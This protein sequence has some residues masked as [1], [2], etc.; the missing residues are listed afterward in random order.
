MIWNRVKISSFL[1]ERPDRIKPDQANETGLKRLKK[2][3]FSGKIHLDGNK[4]TRTGMILVKKGDLVISGINAEKGAVAVYMGEENVLATIHYSSYDLDKDKIDVEY[5]KWFLKSDTFRSAINSQTKGGI[6]TELKPKKFL[7]L[8]I[9]LPDLD[10]QI[11]IRN[12]LNAVNNEIN[13]TID[14]QYENDKLLSK[15]RQ[16][17][18]SEAI[19]GKLIPQDPNDESASALLKKIK[20]EKEKLVEKKN[21]RKE[22]FPIITAE[23]EPYQPPEGWIWVRLGEISDNIHY[24]FNASAKLDKDI[25]LLRITDIQ[26]NRVN[27]ET[28]PGCEI[29]DKEYLNYSLRD[30]DIL[31]ARTGGTIG[32]SFIVKDVHQKAVFASYLIRVIPNIHMD[33]DYMKKFIESPLYWKQLYKASM[34]TGQPNVNGTSLKSLKFPLP[35]LNEQKRI[36]EKT[37]QLM[38]FCDQL[39]SQ[40]KS[41][42]KNSEALM[43]SVVAEAFEVKAEIFG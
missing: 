11:E 33:A 22:S 29:T 3:D 36:V 38:Q 23:E 8:E 1:K 18:L 19:K 24:G 42:Q 16:E 9:D 26:N 34:G 17:I 12:K 20:A 10:T 41:N 15:L 37:G 13:E 7:P 43:T 6:K 39:E 21:I 25:K 40:V 32:K 2:I 4:P 31:I 5:F 35:P 28:V 14:I 27:W 30:K